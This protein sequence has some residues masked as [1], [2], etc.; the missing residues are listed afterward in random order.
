[1]LE[2]LVSDERVAVRTEAA[3][4]LQ[5]AD[6]SH[7]LRAR[8]DDPDVD[9]RLLVLSSL[10]PRQ[11]VTVTWFGRDQSP[12][13][14]ATMLPQAQD[15]EARALLTH[16]AGDAEPAVR[17]A[18][19]E[20]LLKRDPPLADDVYRRLAADPDEQVRQTMVRLVHPDLAL[21]TELHV[22]LAHDAAPPVVAEV[23]NLLARGDWN[24]HGAWLAPVLRARLQNAAIPPGSDN[25]SRGLM[26]APAAVHE[27]TRAWLDAGVEVALRLMVK[28]S[29]DSNGNF[30]G[31]R[32]ID[33]WCKL[34]GADLARLL[35]ALQADAPDAVVRVARAADVRQADPSWPDALEPVARDARQPLRLRLAA[36][37]FVVLAP[38]EARQKL[39]FDLLADPALA[40]GTPDDGTD[41]ALVDAIMSALPQSSRNAVVRYVLE[42]TQLRRQL[43]S[44]LLYNSSPEGPDAGPLARLIVDRFL[45]DADMS[46]RVAR[47][48]VTLG[49]HPELVDEEFMRRALHSS[50]YATGTSVWS[51]IA[52]LARLRDPRF[53]GLLRECLD[54]T[55]LADTGTEGG[56]PSDLAV[57]AVEAIH[58]YMSDEAA[59]ILLEAAANS[60]RAKVRD[61]ALEAVEAIGR[62]RDALSD[63]QRRTTVSATRDAAIVRLAEIARDAKA[64][65]AMRAEALRGLGTLQAAEQ[66]P[67]LIE[68]LASDDAAIREAARAALERLNAPPVPA[69]VQEAAP[70]KDG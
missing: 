19:A 37:K 11:R 49:D 65:G 43:L 66:M 47:A 41:V 9:M 54:P 15:D 3:R 4:A 8:V 63:W 69:K 53:L 50:S 45:G 42:H 40:E 64:T 20:A 17:G 16:L 29:L 24:R 23:D 14:T 55:W 25:A 48:I 22:A 68:S 70:A 28:S 26:N 12:G 7:A 59:A 56:Q 44:I 51:A 38:N 61:A 2:A 46:D 57:K 21:Q 34:N 33:E 31:S 30:G 1:L 32:P 58:G 5:P 13:S 39:L 18:V 52:A 62:Y 6:L 10:L 60:P 67:L 36:C 27:L 35:P